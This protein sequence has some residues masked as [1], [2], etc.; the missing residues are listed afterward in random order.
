[1][2]SLY[3]SSFFSAS[4]F[5]SSVSRPR[6]SVVALQNSFLSY[7]LRTLVTKVSMSS[8]K[9]RTSYPFA[10]TGSTWGRSFA[11]AAVSAVT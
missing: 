7:S 6:S 4:F 10:R 8:V 11:W 2:R 9:A 5:S 1:M 3:S